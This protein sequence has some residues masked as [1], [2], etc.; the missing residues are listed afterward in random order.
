MGNLTQNRVSESD[1]SDTV[2]R[3][4]NEDIDPELRGYLRLP[5]TCALIKLAGFV[6]DKALFL[7][8]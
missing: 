1:K 3:I 6:T 4:N 5:G 2:A 7:G 8:E